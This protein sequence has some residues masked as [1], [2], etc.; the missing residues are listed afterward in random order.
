MKNII[1]VVLVIIGTLVG[2]G[3]ASGKEIYSFFF[4]YNIYGIIGIIISSI[5]IGLVVY[6]VFNICSKNNIN[7]YHE[8]C[9][10]IGRA[11]V[12]N[13]LN[14]IVNI[15]LL[16]AYFVMIAGFSS[17]LRQEFSIN[18]VLASSIIVFLCYFIFLKNI[19]GLIKISNYL[20]PILI[21][22]IIYISC[23]N[24]IFNIKLFYNDN[25]IMNS[26]NINALNINI[27]I[28]KTGEFICTNRY[29]N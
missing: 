13:F 5:I 7:T 18:G 15:F 3:F 25:L 12:S 20:M 6:R 27:S 10:F 9:G 24:G 8:L 17:F 4:V 11:K 28:I 23:K 29:D 1:K 21:F 16:I 2:A 26:S 14:N 22:F 19:S